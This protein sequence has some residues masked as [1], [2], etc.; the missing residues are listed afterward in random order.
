MADD[1]NIDNQ[2]PS[3]ISVGAKPHRLD[4]LVKQWRRA[5]P[6][7]TDAIVLRRGSFLL[8]ALVAGLVSGFGGGLLAGARDDTHGTSLSDQKRIVSN[9]GELLAAPI[10]ATT[11]TWHF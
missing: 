5:L 8:V 7:R 6:A 10:T 11:W 9:Q 3:S 1:K 2:P 4:G